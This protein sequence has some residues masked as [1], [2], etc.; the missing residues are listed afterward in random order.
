[1]GITT[2]VRLVSVAEKVD[3]IRRYLEAHRVDEV[4]RAAEN[5]CTLQTLRNLVYSDAT[6]EN[7]TTFKNG[8]LD[9]VIARLPPFELMLHYE[10]YRGFLRTK[11]MTSENV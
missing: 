9:R 10:A 11:T 7:S 8:N 3:R 4:R 1:M 5:I 2:G 6:P